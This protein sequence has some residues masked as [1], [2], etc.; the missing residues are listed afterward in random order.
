MTRLLWVPISQGLHHYFRRESE[1]DPWIYKCRDFAHARKAN[2]KSGI[3]NRIAAGHCRTMIY[4]Q[5]RELRSRHSN[6]SMRIG[7][8]GRNGMGL[9][10]ISYNRLISSSFF[11]FLIPHPCPAF[12]SVVPKKAGDVGADETDLITHVVG[13]SLLTLGRWLSLRRGDSRGGER[14]REW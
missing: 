6:R 12:S 9:L 10:T 3:T 5:R 7:S 14:L 2:N 13:H 1:C 8:G 11:S 4:F